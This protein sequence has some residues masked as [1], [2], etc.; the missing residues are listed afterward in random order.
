MSRQVR[1]STWPPL[2]SGRRAPGLAPVDPR[3]HHRAVDGPHHQCTV[4]TKRGR[5]KASSSR[6]ALPR[7]GRASR[8]PSRGSPDRRGPPP[9][10]WGPGSARRRR[11]GS[12][13]RARIRDERGGR[14]ALRSRGGRRDDLG[15]RRRSPPQFRHGVR[16]E[17]AAFDVVAGSSSSSQR[18]A[19]R[20]SLACAAQVSA[21]C[22]SARGS[23]QP[24]TKAASASERSAANGSPRKGKGRRLRICERSRGSGNR[25]KLSSRSLGVS[26]SRV[27]H[28]SV[29]TR[30][31]DR[32]QFRHR[33]EEAVDVGIGDHE[34]AQQFQRRARRKL[35]QVRTQPLPR[36]GP[37]E[38]SQVELPG[39][40]CGHDEGLVAVGPQAHVGEDRT[41]GVH[42]H[43]EVAGGEVVDGEPLEQDAVAPE[44]LR[45]KP[46]E[47]VAVDRPAPCEPDGRDLDSRSTSYRRWA[48]EKDAS[49]VLPHHSTLGAC[50][51][52]PPFT[53]PRNIPR[54]LR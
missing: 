46:V 22:A 3:P 17:A 47:L 48:L 4:S 7:A 18:L 12:V 51:V 2:A 14:P 26:Y 34:I 10:G 1:S 49:P 21:I 15:E 31:F 8:R 54:R 23:D 45:G 42:H 25:E 9:A 19:T 36:S 41:Y 29:E 32:Q 50:L 30:P 35:A 37:R 38:W 43:E 28:A 27:G 53:S 13:R 11:R 20:D 33:V 44:A 52:M 24:R 40:G 39:A 6:A 5:S 16:V